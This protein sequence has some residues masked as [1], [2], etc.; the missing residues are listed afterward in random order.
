MFKGTFQVHFSFFSTIAV[1]KVHCL[2][3]LSLSLNI[4][5]KVAAPLSKLKKIILI[6]GEKKSLSECRSNNNVNF[7]KLLLGEVGEV[8]TNLSKLEQTKYWQYQSGDKWRPAS[9]SWSS[10]HNMFLSRGQS[11]RNDFFSSIIFNN[12]TTSCPDLA[13]E[14]T[15]CI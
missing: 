11:Q 10:H 9:S 3:S 7:D 2:V 6:S 4:A 5:G 12:I 13:S 14:N 1:C 8:T 15:D